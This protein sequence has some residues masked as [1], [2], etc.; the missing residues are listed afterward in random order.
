MKTKRILWVLAAF[1]F[2][3][4]LYA[5]RA[6]APIPATNPSQQPSQMSQP[7]P[8]EQ[9]NPAQPAK[10]AQRP[11]TGPVPLTEKEVTKEI[12]SSPAETVIKDVRERGVDFDMTPDIEKKLRKAKATDEVVEAVRRAG[13]KVRAQTARMTLG[14]GQTA[15]FDIPKEQYQAFDAIKGELDPDKT[16]SLVA[17]FESK[18]PQSPLLSYV[19][20]YGANGYQQKG[21]VEK[22]VELTDKGLKLKPDNIMCLI[23]SLGMLPQPQYLNN[24]PTERDKILQKAQN[25]AAQ[26]LKLIAALPKLTNEADADYQKRLNQIAS[27]VHASLGMVYLD[28]ANEALAG[29]DKDELA[30]SEQEFTTAVAVD[31]PDPRDYYRMGEAYA[32]DGKVDDAIGAFTKASEYG[33]GTMIKAYA[34]QRAEELKKKKA[35]ASTAPKS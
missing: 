2:T 18:Y 20:T 34:D 30:K 8:Q 10:P 21:E 16:I 3:S 28:L 22:V 19:Y 1:A 9:Q 25:E 29:P 5:Q 13:P 4:F 35:Q 7:Q 23:L 32:M 14:Q 33:Q 6:Q 27:A 15:S 17:D 24:H 11:S 12:K 26:A 31:H